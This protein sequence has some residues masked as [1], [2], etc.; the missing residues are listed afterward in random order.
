MEKHEL[1]KLVA[2]YIV[3]VGTEGV[4]NSYLWMQ[5]DPNMGDLDRH[6]T[7]LGTLKSA[8]L[9]RESNSFLTLTEKGLEMHKRLEEIYPPAK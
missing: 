1:N 8:G 6:L 7:I 2:T 3:G 5:V 4:P 9:V